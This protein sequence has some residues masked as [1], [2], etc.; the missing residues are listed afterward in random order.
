[1]TLKALIRLLK[2]RRVWAV[3]YRC[4]SS[5]RKLRGFC[6]LTVT[7]TG[8]NLPRQQPCLGGNHPMIEQPGSREFLGWFYEGEGLERVQSA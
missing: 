1:M 6:G 5:D 4:S 2:R 8:F 7:Q 3:T